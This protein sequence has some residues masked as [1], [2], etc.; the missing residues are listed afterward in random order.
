MSSKK[1]FLAIFEAGVA[2]VGP[3]LDHRLAVISHLKVD[4]RTTTDSRQARE[5]SHR[6]AE[7]SSFDCSFPTIA[8]GRRTQSR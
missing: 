7:A 6:V 8:V 3:R 1:V 4:G 2:K 5:G